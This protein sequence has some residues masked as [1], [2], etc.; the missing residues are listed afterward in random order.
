MESL[1]QTLCQLGKHDSNQQPG[2]M[3]RFLAA[4]TAPR[5]TE[6]A[7]FVAAERQDYRAN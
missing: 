2:A 1:G 7:V 4:K 3:Q 6:M 5:T